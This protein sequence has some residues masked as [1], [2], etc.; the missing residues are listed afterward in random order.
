MK[1]QN[2]QSYWDK[3]LEV[4]GHAEGALPM[5]AAQGESLTA[6]LETGK[7]LDVKEIEVIDPEMVG[8]YTT[9]QIHP[10]TAAEATAANSCDYQKYF[11]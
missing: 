5:A 6:D 2:K 1:I 7:T 10:A 11:Q 4:V 8:F 9:R 3:A